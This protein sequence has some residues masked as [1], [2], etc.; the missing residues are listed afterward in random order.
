MKITIIGTGYVGLVTGVCLAEIGHK[1]F[2]HDIN[3][4]KIKLLKSKKIPI[5]EN[6]L[7]KLFKKHLE[8]KNLRIESD[9]NEALQASNIYFI[10]VGTPQLRNGKPNLRYLFDISN[11]IKDYIDKNNLNSNTFIVLK[12]TIPPGTTKELQ[13]KIFKKDIYKNVYLGSNPEFLREGNAVYDFMNSERIVIGSESKEFIGTLKKIYS[14]LSKKS[15]IFITDPQSSELIKYGSNAFLATKISFINEMSKLSDKVGGNIDDVSQGIGMDKRIGNEFLNAGLGYGGSC[16]PKDTRGLAYTFSK[17]KIPS[18]ILKSVID[19]NNKQRK[20][21][22]NK[23][24][25]RFSKQELKSKSVLFLGTAFKPNTDDIR[26][27]VGIHLINM[28]SPMVKNISIFEPIA[29][30]N[31]INALSEL[32]NVRFQKTSIPKIDNDCDFMI[33]A[34]EYPEFIKIPYKNLKKLKDRVVFDG[35]NILNREKLEKNGIEYIGIGK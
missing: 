4:E 35:R 27:S 11:K 28:I 32:S 29:K 15:K 14:P 6:G 19:I 33:I 12:S 9:P 18:K 17:N 10:C 2:L 24:L 16:F 34:T 23:I 30:E 13:T 31:S 21:F 22:L 8:A 20:Y 7:L 1:V 3:Q 5:H 25:K 26:E